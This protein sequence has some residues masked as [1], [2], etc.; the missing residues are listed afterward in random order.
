MGLFFCAL[1]VLGFQFI[2]SQRLLYQSKAAETANVFF[3]KASVTAP[4]NTEF[5]L[6]VMIRPSA[7]FLMQYSSVIIS[8]DK[9]KI[10][11]KDGGLIY[12]LGQASIN[13]KA[14]TDSALVNSSGIIELSNEIVY[15][16]EGFILPA[17][18]TELA[19]M[20]FTSESDVESTI[21]IQT[22]GS[23]IKKVRP[24]FTFETIVFG[25]F[26]TKVNPGTISGTSTPTPTPTQASGLTPTPTTRAGDSGVLL[27]IKLIFQGITKLPKQGL[28]K[29][30]TQITLEDNGSTSVEK[31][32]DFT[33]DN[34][35]VWRG[36]VQ[37]SP[38]VAAGKTFTVFT[39]GPKHL[40][41]TFTN[42]TLVQGNNNLD[43][44]GKIQ[45][46]GDLDRNDELNSVDL[47]FVYNNL[48]KSTTDA[49]TKADVNLDG[50]VN[51]VDFSLLIEALIAI[52]GE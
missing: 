34:I 22:G 38:L 19:E 3:D 10:H 25:E 30:T 11:L 42:V 15:P 13:T 40:T 33:S 7:S 26:A 12:K 27:N 35:G 29:L 1:F 9:T 2:K 5:T 28:N 16:A 18:D 45:L 23:Y 32:A 8:F 51:A 47:A 46:A 4:N 24:N 41:Q 48:D 49:V 14:S 44:K 36:S 39:K 31:T 52:Q 37:F 21:T 50:V 17:G 6:K 20:T 43:L